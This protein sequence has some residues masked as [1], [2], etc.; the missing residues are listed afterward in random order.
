[1]SGGTGVIAA[2]HINLVNWFLRRDGN[3]QRDEG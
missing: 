2:V 3:K 1:M